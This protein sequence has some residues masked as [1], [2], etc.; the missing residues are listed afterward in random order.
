MN[1]LQVILGPN[2]YNKIDINVNTLQAYTFSILKLQNQINCV[3]ARKVYFTYLDT[4]TWPLRDSLRFMTVVNS[5][6]HV[7]GNFTLTEMLQRPSQR[8]FADY[9]KMLT[10]LIKVSCKKYCYPRETLSFS[11]VGMQ[12]CRVGFLIFRVQLTLG[13]CHTPLHPPRSH[14]PALN[15]IE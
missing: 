4:S 12:M 10:E 2:C 9:E 6:I 15:N 8:H 13:G 3:S 5:T 14:G 11:R 1:T 7:L